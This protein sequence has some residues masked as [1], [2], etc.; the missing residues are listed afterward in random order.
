MTNHEKGMFFVALLDSP[1][2]DYWIKP[3]FCCKNNC[4]FALRSLLDE[5]NSLWRPAIPLYH[6]LSIKNHSFKELHFIINFK[7]KVD[8]H[9]K[10]ENVCHIPANW[11]ITARKR[12][13][14]SR[15]STS[16]NST[17]FMHPVDLLLISSQ[18]YCLMHWFK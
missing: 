17:M 3:K 7:S 15:N 13:V 1:D 8:I 9:E 6:W 10:P 11:K 16:R 2:N 18:I 14:M 5:N 4:N 12:A